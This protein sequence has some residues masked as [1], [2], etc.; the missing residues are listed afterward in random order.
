LNPVGVISL[1]YTDDTLLF[2]SHRDDSA[3]HIKWLMIYFEKLSEM[4]I[5]YHK[6]DLIPINLE[7]EETQAYAKCLF[8]K[9]GKFLFTYLGVPL[10][11]ER[12]RREDIQPVVDKIMKRIAGWEGRLL[13]YRTK[14]N[15]L[16]ACLASIPIYLMS[17]IKFTKWAIEA[18][19]SQLAKLFC[20]DDEDKHRFHLSN[21]HSLCIKKEHGGLGIPELRNLNMCLLAS[22]IQRYQDSDN[23]LWKDIVDTKYDTCSPNIICSKDRNASPFGKG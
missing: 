11:H 12:L 10:H 19:N 6:S 13:S 2:L 5:N 17:I 22:W 14:L 1:Q 3:N 20:D 8:C 23:K 18:I 21:I 15:L 16:K 9:I 4:R 7:E